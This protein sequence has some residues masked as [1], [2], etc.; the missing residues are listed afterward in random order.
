MTNVQIGNKLI[1]PGNPC[2]IVAEI[3]L[4]HNGDINIAKKLIDSAV[5]AGCDAVKFQKRT[6]EKCVPR[7]QWNIERETPW[8]CMTYM[9]YRHKMEFGF[10]EY[11]AIDNYCHEKGILWFASCWDEESVDFIDQFNPVCYKIAS[12]S[13]TD[14]NLLLHT[15]AKNKPIIISTGMSTMEQVIKAVEILG[16]DDLVILHCVAT[17][18]AK[19][20]E[21]NLSVIQTLKQVFSDIPIGY[22][23]HEVRLSPSIMA[24][25]LGADVVERHIT[26]D[27]TMWGTDQAAS[28]EPRGIQLLVR[29][30]RVWEIA[31]GDGI[32]RVLPSEIPIMAKL[33]RRIDF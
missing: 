33:R 13:L 31:K 1:G 20:E 3:G 22:S 15:R 10:E 29:D 16:S 14:K 28:M 11:K 9:D 24:V 26:L 8:G 30:V 25:V 2:F 27:H 6:P 7:D 12:P 4:N 23:G 18:P 17:Y 21:L 5:E 32:K 19:L